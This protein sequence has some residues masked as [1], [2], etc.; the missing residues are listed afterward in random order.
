MRFPPARCNNARLAIAPCSRII[1]APRSSSIDRLRVCMEVMVR[2]R[3]V[4][5]S[6]SVRPQLGHPLDES[7]VAPQ[8]EQG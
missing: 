4:I 2:F 6:P 8:F 3:S 7:A 5:S 1:S